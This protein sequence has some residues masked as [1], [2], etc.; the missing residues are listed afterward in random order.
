MAKLFSEDAWAA[1]WNAPAH[2]R[3]KEFLDPLLA[4]SIDAGGI[5]TMVER[6]SIEEAAALAAAIA[7]AASHV[8]NRGT[9]IVYDNLDLLES[10]QE[11]TQIYSSTVNAISSLKDHLSGDYPRTKSACVVLVTRTRVHYRIQAGIGDFGPPNSCLNGVFDPVEIF[12]QRIRYMKKLVKEEDDPE[13]WP[14]IRRLYDLDHILSDDPLRKDLSHLFNG[15]YRTFIDHVYHSLVQSGLS[16][17]LPAPPLGQVR[18]CIRGN[19][20]EARC[21]RNYAWDRVVISIMRDGRLR[22][23]LPEYPIWKPQ[24]GYKDDGNLN[25][26]R[27]MLNVIYAA[28]K[29][30]VDE[31]DLPGMGV[32]ELFDSVSR[33]QLGEEEHNRDESIEC[34]IQLHGGDT[35]PPWARPL[36]LAGITE[37]SGTALLDGLENRSAK[38]KVTRAGCVYLERILPNLS[39]FAQL[40]GCDQVRDLYQPLF[41]DFGHVNY[42]TWFAR[43]LDVAKEGLLQCSRDLQLFATSHLVREERFSCLGDLVNTELVFEHQLHAERLARSFRDE[44]DDLRSVWRKILGMSAP[45]VL[46]NAADSFSEIH[47]DLL[48]RHR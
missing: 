24:S 37:L 5:E 46:I 18:A 20:I 29:D 39:V 8:E 41:E 7:I 13:R 17:R 22:G 42:G 3:Q 33:V 40:H 34:L 27:T 23:V 10:T 48:K 30:Y 36:Q 38:V 12:K 9:I 11:I 44:V 35:E 26:A 19:E 21:A 1:Y 4:E 16:A 31:P 25:L 6:M 32:K 14:E 2:R 28:T 43:I 47:Q 45:S 15:N